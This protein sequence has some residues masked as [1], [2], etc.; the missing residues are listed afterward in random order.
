MFRKT[1]NYLT[2]A[3][4]EK[5]ISGG[6]TGVDQAALNAAIALHINCGG[7]CPPNR[8]CENGKIPDHFPLKETPTERSET[9][10][11]VPRSLRTEWNVRDSDATLVIKPSDLKEDKGIEWTLRCIKSYKKPSLIIDPS[12]NEASTKM[13]EW[14]NKYKIK[15]LNIAGP[16][17]K[18]Y[19][20]ISSRTY[21]LF[22]NAFRHTGNL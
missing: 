1:G 9:A 12:E 2:V 13:K 19:P 16:S 20:G 10:P 4:I 3:R 18:T 8:I 14:F 6:Q 7:W 15:I 17:E 11:N 21:K 5:I 22:L